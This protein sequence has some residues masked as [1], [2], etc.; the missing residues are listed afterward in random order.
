MS[1]THY[2]R[3]K[4]VLQFYYKRGQNRENVKEVYRKI[5]K[6]KSK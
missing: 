1:Q 5:L 3:I 4:R 6:E 2:Q